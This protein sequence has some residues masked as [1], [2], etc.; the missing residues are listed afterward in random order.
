VVVHYI[1]R[2]DQEKIGPDTGQETLQYGTHAQTRVLVCACIHCITNGEDVEDDGESSHKEKAAQKDVIVNELTLIAHNRLRAHTHTNTHTGRM[3]TGSHMVAMVHSSGISHIISSLSQHDRP[4]LLF[5]AIAFATFAAAFPL[6][7][8]SSQT[9]VVEYKDASSSCRSR[10][11]VCVC[12]RVQVRRNTNAPANIKTVNSLHWLENTTHT[13]VHTGIYRRRH[14]D[15]YLVLETGSWDRL[16]E[17]FSSSAVMYVG[18][19]LLILT[20]YISFLQCF[21]VFS[22]LQETTMRFV[23]GQSIATRTVIALHSGGGSGRLWC[24][25]TFAMSADAASSLKNVR[26]RYAPSPTGAMHLGGLRTALYNYLFAKR[27]GG[28][29]ILRIEDTDKTR[30]VSLLARSS[31]QRF[32]SSSAQRFLL[33]S[34]PRILNFTRMYHVCACLGT[35]MCDS[36]CVFVPCAIALFVVQV[37]GSA[38]TLIE[39]I[40]LCTLLSFCSVRISVTVHTCM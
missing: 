1:T 34:L 10:N 37:P 4:C 7:S 39:V 40:F 16:E 17:L 32:L 29:F 9:C 26:V 21:G 28:T 5:L 35:C 3:F 22:N 36:K 33:L 38:A 6:A 25:R 31:A 2:S 27:H 14:D 12:M 24:M 30:E 19:L 8:I 15:V 11:I 23:L 13:G 20:S 18:A